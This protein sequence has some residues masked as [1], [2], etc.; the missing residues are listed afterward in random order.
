MYLLSDEFFSL[1]IKNPSRMNYT[2]G[3]EIFYAL[4]TLAFL[5]Q[6]LPSMNLDTMNDTT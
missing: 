1:D 3:A 5:S 2:G 4:A 6:S